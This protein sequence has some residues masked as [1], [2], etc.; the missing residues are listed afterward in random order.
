MNW[1]FGSSARAFNVAD[2]DAGKIA[3]NAEQIEQPND[4]GDENHD[5]HDFLNAGLHRNVTVY[6]PKQ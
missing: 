5:V 2:S 1:S 6:E 3:K 4:D